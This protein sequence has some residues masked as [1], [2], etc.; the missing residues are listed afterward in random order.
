[1]RKII[2]LTGVSGVGKGFTATKYC[3]LKKSVLHLVASDILKDELKVKKEQLRVSEKSKIEDNQEV[4]VKAFHKALANK[5]SDVAVIFDCHMIIDNDHELVQ[6]PLQVFRDI[7]ISQ[8][9]FVY[10]KPMTIYERRKNDI[11]RTRPERDESDIENQQDNA[12]DV[13]RN[14][15]SQL[16]VPISIISPCPKE[17]EKTQSS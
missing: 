6:I 16:N 13:A 11:D 12:L 9:I 15:A 2:C 8:I 10:D 4:L 3:G 14:Y 17:L 7:N 1:M 5:A